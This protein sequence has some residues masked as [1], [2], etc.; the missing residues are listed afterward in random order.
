MSAARRG[1]TAEASP[2]ERRRQLVRCIAADDVLV[3]WLRDHVAGQLEAIATAVEASE[4]PTVEVAAAAIRTRA[5]AH[6]RGDTALW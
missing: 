3:D 6:R 5:S 1:R 2:E 4:P